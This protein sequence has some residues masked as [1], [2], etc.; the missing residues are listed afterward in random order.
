MKKNDLLDTFADQLGNFK[1][2]D[3]T[4]RR[5]QCGCQFGIQPNVAG[6]VQLV[7]LDV[8]PQLFRN[9]GTAGAFDVQ[10]PG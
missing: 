1:H 9:V 2:V 10:K 4:R 5:A 7:R 6:M 8:R 3:R